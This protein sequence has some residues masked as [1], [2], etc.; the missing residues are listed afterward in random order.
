[1][2][3]LRLFIWK[4]WEAWLVFLCIKSVA[5]N[6]LCDALICEIIMFKGAKTA[7]FPMITGLVGILFK[8]KQVHQCTHAISCLEIMYS[9]SSSPRID[10]WW[11]RESYL[12]LVMNWHHFS[13]VLVSYRQMA[14]KVMS[15]TLELL[16]MDPWNLFL[17][18]FRGFH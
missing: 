11:K 10:R 13:F 17:C 16:Y 1:M 12:V 2:W 3:Q 4:F 8:S 9:W 18:C 6:C 7:F 15:F 5:L 14:T